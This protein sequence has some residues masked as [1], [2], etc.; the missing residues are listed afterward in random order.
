[1]LSPDI[2]CF[3]SAEGCSDRVDVDHLFA[4]ARLATHCWCGVTAAESK[5]TVL[6]TGQRSMKATA[7]RWTEIRLRSNGSC[8]QTESKGAMHV[9]AFIFVF[10]GLCG[11]RRGRRRR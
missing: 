4:A 6:L 3:D 9:T 8:G 5:A 11:Q 1:M 2:M 7:F 10:N